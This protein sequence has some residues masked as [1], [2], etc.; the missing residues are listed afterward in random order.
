MRVERPAAERSAAVG[1][2]IAWSRVKEVR[3]EREKGLGR[4]S[5]GGRRSTVVFKRPVD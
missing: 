5:A 4:W 1:G 3:L 2:A